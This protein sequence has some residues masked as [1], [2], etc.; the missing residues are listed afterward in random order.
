MRFSLTLLASALVA[1]VSAQATKGNNAF[2]VP[3][4][5]YL[6]HAG[7]PTTFTWTKLSGSTVTIKLRRGDRSDLDSGVTLTSDLPNTGSYTFNVPAST[8]EDVDYALEIINNDDPTD[9]NYTGQFDILSSVK[10]VPSASSSGAA[11][12]AAASGAATSGTASASASGAAVSTLTTTIASGT[13][14]TTATHPVTT[15]FHNSTSTSTV[16]PSKSGSSTKTS[17]APSGTKTGAPANNAASG[18]KVGGAMLALAAGVAI[19]L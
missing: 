1:L 15:G 17:A 16:S 2:S 14:A 13:A 19:L 3:E 11:S 6:L 8:P 7:Q 9:I 12:T 4:G 5:G 10:N 18:L